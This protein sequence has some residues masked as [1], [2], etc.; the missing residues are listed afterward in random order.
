MAKK[1]NRLP[2]FVAIVKEMLRS[3]AWAELTNAS[4]VAYVHLKDKCVSYEQSDITLS[5]REMERIMSRHTFSHA[6]DQLEEVGFIIK[7]QRGGLYRKR[8][9][10]RFIDEW[11]NYKKKTVK[12]IN[13]SAV[14]A[15]S[16]VQ[17]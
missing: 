12:K 11:R 1:K 16:V 10:Y 2:P 3:D 9:Y 6:I 5:F 13:S 17:F 14:S 15:P 7:Q 4:R 8:N